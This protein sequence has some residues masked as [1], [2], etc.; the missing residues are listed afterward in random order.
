VRILF[1]S[2]GLGE[3]GT[4]RAVWDYATQLKL[5][6]NH[7]PVIALN[8]S[9]DNNATIVQKFAD[10]FEIFPYAH[11][12]ELHNAA[13]SAAL[14]SAY[15]IKSGERDDRRVDGIPNY[16]HAVFRRFQP[17]GTRYAYV[18]QWL[19]EFMWRMTPIH[20]TALRIKGADPNVYV[21][22]ESGGRSFNW[23]PHMANPLPPSATKLEVRSEFGIPEE[24]YVVGSLSGRNEFNIGFVRDWLPSF[25][26]LSPRNYFLGPNIEPFLEHPRALFLPTILNDQLK[27]NYVNSLDVML[28]ARQSG[29]SFGLAICEALAL[30]VPVVSCSRGRD[31]HHV[32]L[33][34]ETG[35]MYRNRSELETVIGALEV[36]SVD[37]GEIARQLV[38]QFAPNPVMAQFHRVFTSQP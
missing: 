16:V 20:R 10:N 29:E 15:L 27:S 37:R 23:I 24:A 31:R 3:R 22:R 14:D 4:S 28:H 9:T 18:S 25:L 30:G 36:P 1:Q 38:S 35:W 6:S 8:V 26:A 2:N 33:L 17:H 11:L 32:Q 34:K 7:I 19:S 5:E 12:S 13:N 21:S